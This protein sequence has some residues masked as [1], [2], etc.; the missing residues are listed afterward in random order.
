MDSVNCKSPQ[1][2]ILDK[3]KHLL[4]MDF[5]FFFFKWICI[6]LCLLVDTS[7]LKTSVFFIKILALL[8]EK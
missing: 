4:E 2:P 7:Y 8:F 5:F 6:K 1:S 3:L